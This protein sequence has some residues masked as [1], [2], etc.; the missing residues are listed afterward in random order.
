MLKRA[1]FA[2]IGLTLVVGGIRLGAPDPSSAVGAAHR[3]A[4]FEESHEATIA[5]VA[6]TNSRS[7]RIALIDAITAAFF[8][9]AIGA[10]AISTIC[11]PRSHRAIEHFSIQ[12]RGPP[13]VLVTG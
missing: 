13:P 8:S 4:R 9:A 5:G 12:R 1:L 10:I 11:S 2:V 3:A 6:V 7:R